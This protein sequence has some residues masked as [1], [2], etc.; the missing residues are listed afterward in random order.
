MRSD[1]WHE[2]RRERPDAIS[3]LRDRLVADPP[4]PLA[5]HPEPLEDPPE[6]LAD[7]PNKPDS[8]TCS[9]ADR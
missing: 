1:D 6:P 2:Q 7:P 4:E 5:G 9:S 8:R 3:R